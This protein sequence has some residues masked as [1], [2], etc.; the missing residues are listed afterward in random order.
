MVNQTTVASSQ[1]PTGV[2]PVAIGRILLTAVVLVMVLL[3]AADRF[4][5]LI[6]AGGL[7]MVRAVDLLLLL[8]GAVSFFL[9]LRTH[10]LAK[11]LRPSLY[12][13]LVTAATLLLVV[14]NTQ[15]CVECGRDSF[16]RPTT[17]LRGLALLVASHLVFVTYS[18]EQRSRGVLI[19][20]TWATIWAAASTFLLVNPQ[21][22]GP[23]L[24]SETPYLH[25]PF[26]SPVQ[27]ANFLAAILLLGSGAALTLN[28]PRF[29]YV[30][31][32]ALTLAIAQSGSRSGMVLLLLCWLGFIT[33]Y[34][35][36]RWLVDGRRVPRTL[37]H[38]IVSAAV[39]AVAIGVLRTPEMARSLS[40][41]G[42]APRQ[43]A[44]GQ[45]DAYRSRVWRRVLD[46]WRQ[47]SGPG[48]TVAADSR[49]DAGNVR[50]IRGGERASA[51]GERD[52]RSRPARSNAPLS[53]T[54]GASG[55][56]DPSPY[57]PSHGD[58]EEPAAVDIDVVAPAGREAPHNIY[59]EYLLYGGVASVA[60]LIAVL[61][62]LAGMTLR[63]VWETRRSH[64]F[65]FAVALMFAVLFVAAINFGNVTLHLSFV[66]VLFGLATAC[67][68]AGFQRTA[69][70]SEVVVHE[71]PGP[72][73]TQQM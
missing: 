40:F 34:I 60:A 4:T 10:G 39:A 31:V 28:R 5:I 63:H 15:T 50:E 55:A 32:P 54:A 20:T 2:A 59:L 58:Q 45:P 42:L 12:L 19:V 69:N 61:A 25:K 68:S 35:A 47:D 13:A 23:L 3:P 7:R 67:V 33:L 46:T 6:E 9:L 11:L 8:L 49:Q 64:M 17:I 38:L 18:A 16:A 72:A 26:T 41:I 53:R 36:Q 73:L 22:A 30:F 48:R 57:A 52:P 14:I 71:A 56:L 29:L 27:A 66:W 21:W 51:A 65:P 43:I 37:V 70:R 24:Y 62:I 44:V 1:P